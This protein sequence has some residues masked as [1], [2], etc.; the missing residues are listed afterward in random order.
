MKAFNLTVHSRIILTLLIPS[1]FLI[2]INIWAFHT[3]NKVFSDA[4]TIRQQGVELSLLAKD[5]K[6]DVVQVQQ[7]LTDISATRGLDDLNDGF[8]MAE[9]SADSFRKRLDEAK[10]RLSK[11][12]SNT[13]LHS[14]NAMETSFNAY[15][16]IGRQMAQ[17]YVDHG[18]S[19]GNKQMAEFDKRAD[20][21]H[22]HL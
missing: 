18:P 6:L 2:G 17:A 10:K 9:K 4:V 11:E 14:L 3:S 1:V 19:A 21:L 7:W 16:T 8:I 5:M 13:L 20:E 22:S 15:Y 12:N